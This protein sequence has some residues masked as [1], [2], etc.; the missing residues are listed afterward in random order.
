MNLN[1]RYLFF[2]LFLTIVIS[3][4]GCGLKTQIQ[5]IKI[6]NLP[7][8]LNDLKIA[9]LSDLHVKENIS[10]Y[11]EIVAKLNEIKPDLIFLTGD[12][13][14][15]SSNI[16]KCIEI[17]R[18]FKAKYGVWAVLGNWD[19]WMGD[20]QELV[21]RLNEVGI[22]ILIN[23]SK[24]IN[25]NST[26]LYLIGVDD[27]FTRKDNLNKAVEGINFNEIHSGEA[28]A[29]LLAHSPDIF[30]LAKQI[31]IP[32]TLAGH[33]HGGQVRLPFIGPVYSL[34][35]TMRKYSVGLFMEGNSQMY[36]NPGIGWS[37]VNFRF[38]CPPELTILNL[39]GSSD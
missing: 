11:R 6:N 2:L 26:T 39:N 28:F 5:P 25:I 8:K 4:I 17:V 34:T 18:H 27:P 12:F 3:L 14:E 35:P 30:E 29:I 23:D 7:N 24:K 19:Y 15:E 1:N 31:K 13:V 9:H 37:Q 32:L 21:K 20:P 10:I 38:L 36:V 22:N 33:T 16:E